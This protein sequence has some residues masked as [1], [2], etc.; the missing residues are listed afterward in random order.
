MSCEA[1]LDTGSVRLSL[2]EEGHAACK[3]RVAASEAI[4]KGAE[5]G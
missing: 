5:A 1:V 3:A 2:T 4:V